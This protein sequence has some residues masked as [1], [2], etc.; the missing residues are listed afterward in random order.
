MNKIFFILLPILPVAAF[1][2]DFS[3]CDVIGHKVYDGN[4]EECMTPPEICKEDPN[5]T[6]CL[7]NIKTAEQCAQEIDNINKLMAENYVIYK[8]P[9]TQER[10]KQKSSAKVTTN[11]NYVYSDGTPVDSTAMIEDSNFVYIF[12]MG[13]GLFGGFTYTD[14][15]Q[16]Y[17]I[18]TPENDGTNLALFKQN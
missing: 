11:V 7:N 13:A 3:D 16:D 12:R 2:A 18:G 9:A 14:N 1:G 17:I 15:Y 4:I 8:C 6:K 5:S 10:I